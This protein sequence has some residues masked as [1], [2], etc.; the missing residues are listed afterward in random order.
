MRHFL[1][2]AQPDFVLHFALVRNPLKPSIQGFGV[3]ISGKETTWK[4]QTQMGG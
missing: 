4:T 2:V 1:P 3:E